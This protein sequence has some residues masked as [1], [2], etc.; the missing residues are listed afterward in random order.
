MMLL[1]VFRL[2]DIFTLTF[3]LDG[4]VC[5]LTVASGRAFSSIG[6][7]LP[8]IDGSSQGLCFPMTHH[9]TILQDIITPPR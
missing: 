4:Y 1:E 7:M 8:K 6:V 3:Y 5:I 9:L 2:G